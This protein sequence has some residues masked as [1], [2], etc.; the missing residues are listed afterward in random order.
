MKKNFEYTILG[1]VMPVTVVIAIV[2]S[3]LTIVA[4]HIGRIGAAIN[5]AVITAIA[6]IG[7]V[8]EFFMVYQT[9][10]D[11]WFSRDRS[12][13]A[14]V[15]FVVSATLAVLISPNHGWNWQTFAVPVIIFIPL[16]FIPYY[17]GVHYGKRLKKFLPHADQTKLAEQERQ[18][19]AN[20]AKTSLDPNMTTEDERQHYDNLVNQ[21]S[22]EF[23]KT[24]PEKL[25]SN[26][27]LFLLILLRENGFLNQGFKP[28]ITNED[29]EIHQS[30]YAFVADCLSAALV[31]NNRKWA[32][33]GE[34][35]GINNGAQSLQSYKQTNRKTPSQHM[36]QIGS[37]FRKATRLRPELLEIDDIKPIL[38][39]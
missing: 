24:L 9:I 8:I 28:V 3:I 37:L 10:V 25:Q 18:I 32:V 21:L 35:W 1:I 31:I 16:F 12:I 34:F 38:R 33:F 19:E 30:L 17:T 23:V 14:A 2:F 22:P 4:Y 13:W 6:L 39:Y 36:K 29:K 20:I 15:W 27:A 7:L 11:R 26:N 5:L